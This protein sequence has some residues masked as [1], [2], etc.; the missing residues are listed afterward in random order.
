MICTAC[1]ASVPEGNA[2]CHLCG[3]KLPEV[4]IPRQSG[5]SPPSG[6][7]GFSGQPRA[8]YRT[9]SAASRYF[10][11]SVVAV[12]LAVIGWLI[13]VLTPIVA[14]LA[15]TADGDGDGGGVSEGEL[16]FY[17]F[18]AILIVGWLYASAFLWFNYSLRLLSDIERNTKK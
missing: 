14:I 5:A 13:A 8:V 1:N 11:S 15:A 6:G 12:F 2:F 3:T 17:V 7:A 16:R 4:M 10:G 18:L 9:T